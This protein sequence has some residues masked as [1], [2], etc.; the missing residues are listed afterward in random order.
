QHEVGAAENGRRDVVWMAF[1]VA[2]ELGQSC[3]IELQLEQR[4]GGGGSRNRRGRGGSESPRDGNVGVG[5][6]REAGGHLLPGPPAGGGEA[7]IQQVCLRRRVEVPERPA[8]LDRN[9]PPGR[10]GRRP[11]GD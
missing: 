3:P 5:G 10:V 11:G 2:A 7:T 8:A 1:E 6:K 9:G 4:R